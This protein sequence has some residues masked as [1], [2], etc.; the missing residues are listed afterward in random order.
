MRLID[1]DKLYI[2]FLKAHKDIHVENR[3]EGSSSGFSTILVERILNAQPTIE[4]KD[5]IKYHV[6]EISRTLNYKAIEAEPVRHGR[7]VWKDFHGDGSLTLCCSEC[8]ETEGARETAKYCHECGAK[9]D[10]EE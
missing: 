10:L 2:A 1:A 5:L 9:M 7:W 6:D 4:A 8:L 3:Y